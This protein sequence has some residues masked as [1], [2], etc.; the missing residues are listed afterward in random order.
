MEIRLQSLPY[1]PPSFSLLT[2]IRTVPT[3]LEAVS[4]GRKRAE[5]KKIQGLTIPNP[6][7]KATHV[8]LM[9]KLGKKAEVAIKD[10]ETLIDTSG[11]FK[12]TRK[13]YKG[14]TIQIWDDHWKWDGKEVTG[15]CRPPK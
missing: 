1:F 11:I 2:S 5:T 7:A 12:Y 10:F 15:R 14:K 13:D 3:L 6:P 4:R 8:L 9:T